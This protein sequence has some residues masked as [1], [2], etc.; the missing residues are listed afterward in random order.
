LTFEPPSSRPAPSKPDIVLDYEESTQPDLT[1]RTDVYDVQAA[2]D[3]VLVV[4][5]RL[6]GSPSRA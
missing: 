3:R 4:I 2:A 5:Q 1:I 6:T